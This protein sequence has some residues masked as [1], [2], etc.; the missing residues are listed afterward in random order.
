MPRFTYG[1][2][3]ERSRTLQ[4]RQVKRQDKTAFRRAQGEKTVF[5]VEAPF[6]GRGRRTKE[7]VVGG[8]PAEGEKRE[9]HGGKSLN[10]RER[11]GKG[12]NQP[13]KKRCGESFS[14]AG[15]R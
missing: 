7:G 2:R 6:Q 9:F 1:E 13:L 12:L 10:D 5:F 3:G 4:E 15:K 14:V 11:G 8:S